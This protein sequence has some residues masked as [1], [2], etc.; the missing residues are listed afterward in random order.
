MRL[1]KKR[2]QSLVEMAMIAPI[3]IMMLVSVI[4]FGRAAYDYSTLAGAVREGARQAALTGS[5]RMTDADVVTAVKR[6]AV[7]LSLAAAPCVNG[8][9]GASWPPSTPASAAPNTGVIYIVSGSSNSPSIDAP[10]G[11][12][13]ANATGSCAAVTPA[14]AGRYPLTVKVLY[15]F[16]PLTPFVQQFLGSGSVTLTVASTMTTEY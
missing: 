2:A 13:P 15:N 4:D 8:T 14:Y 5:T 3:L 12:A 7:G 6:Y 11:Q 16:Q 9:A 10:G 1:R